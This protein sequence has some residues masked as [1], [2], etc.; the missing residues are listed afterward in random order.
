VFF[1]QIFAVEISRHQEI[2]QS[3]QF[4][5]P[6]LDRGSSEDKPMQPPE[7]FDGFELQGFDI[8]NQM[9]LIQDDELQVDG[10][11]YGIVLLD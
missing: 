6:V 5:Q 8:F 3:P 2:E 7:S 9:A 1:K 4:D 11:E 10:V